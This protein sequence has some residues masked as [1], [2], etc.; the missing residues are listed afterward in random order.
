VSRPT[1]SKWL[2]EL[3]DARV[4]RDFRIGRDRL[5]VNAD[6]LEI[7]V[8]DEPPRRRPATNSS[9]PTLP[10]SAVAHIPEE[11]R[12]LRLNTVLRR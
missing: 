6:F 4:L 12:Q 8:R 9:S 3:V 11:R 5:L 7:L 2:S 1:A 10:T